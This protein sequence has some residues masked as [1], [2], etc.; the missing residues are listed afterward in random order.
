MPEIKIV[1]R[2]GTGGSLDYWIVEQRDHEVS[3]LFGPYPTWASTQPRYQ[4]IIA[5]RGA[6]HD[7]KTMRRLRRRQVAIARTL[8]NLRGLA[9]GTLTDRLAKEFS[10]IEHER[11]DIKIHKIQC[12]GCTNELSGLDPVTG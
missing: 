2:P 6:W 7:P 11:A 12:K 3:P 1:S 10:E 4:Q 5:E 9:S 8:A